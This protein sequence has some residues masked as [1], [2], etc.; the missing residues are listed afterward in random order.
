MI[1]L[2]L[3]QIRLIWD[4]TADPC[5]LGCAETIAVRMLKETKTRPALTYKVPGSPPQFGLTE[6]GLL[7]KAEI[8]RRLEHSPLRPIVTRR[9]PA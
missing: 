4:L 5:I 8:E 9:K 6:A 3:N 2:S 7:I 1:R